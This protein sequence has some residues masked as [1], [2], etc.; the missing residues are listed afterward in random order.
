MKLAVG[1]PLVECKAIT[2]PLRN[3]QNQNDEGG[4]QGPTEPP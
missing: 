2:S 1:K 3:A 4:D